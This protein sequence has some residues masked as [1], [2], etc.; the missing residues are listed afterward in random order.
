M[1]H[2]D[3]GF[4]ANK[5]VKGR[6]RHLLVDTLGLMILVVVSAA[7][8]PEREGANL[9]FAKLHLI[10]EKFP[11]LVRIWVDG[12]YEGKDFMRSVMDTYRLIQGN[13][14]TL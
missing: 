1:I 6:K 7:S 10:L 11:R 9:V 12:G 2:T 4:D 13:H 14:Q 3:V 5:K 8:V